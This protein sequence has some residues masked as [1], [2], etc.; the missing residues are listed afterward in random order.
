MTDAPQVRTTPAR[1]PRLPGRDVAFDGA[2]F[3]AGVL[4]ALV[5]LVRWLAGGPALTPALVVAAALVPLISYF[6]FLL[7]QKAGDSNIGLDP[8]VLVF[9]VLTG[10]A[11]QSLALWSLGQLASQLVA[12]RSIRVRLFNFGITVLAGALLVLVLGRGDALVRG[13]AGE[14]V[15]VL[16]GC[17]VYFLVDI[18][19]TAVSLALEMRSRLRDA[20]PWALAPV[21]M[22]VFVGIDTVGYLGMLLYRSQ[23][24]WPLALLLIPI[25]TILFAARS[26][27]RSQL[28]HQQ[29]TS[30]LDATARAPEWAD[31]E[32][33]EDALRTYA[34]QIVR[35]SSAQVRDEPP[36][37]EEIGAVLAVEG[38][39]PRYLV[40]ARLANAEPFSGEDQQ[41][42][43]ALTSVAAT[44]VSR[45]RLADEMAFR[46][47]HDPLTGLVNRATFS[48]RLDHGLLRLRRNPTSLLAVLYCDLDGFK[49][50]NDRL[51]HH[52][53]DQVLIGVAERIRGSL[54]PAD[55]AAR[56][57][58]D[59]FAILLEDLVEP[60]DAEHAAERLLT[61]LRQPLLIDGRPTST[62]AS[63]GLAY[64]DGNT[65][66]VELLRLADAAMYRAKNLGRDRLVTFQHSGGQGSHRLEM[67]DRLRQAV[68][69][70]TIEP[71]FQPIVDLVTGGIQGFEALAR[72][73]DPMLGQIGPDVFI[74]VAEQL[75]LIDELGRQM[76]ARA[77]EV[78]VRLLERTGRP[79]AISVNLAPSQVADSAML[80]MAESL[81]ARHPVVPLTLE[82]TERT[83]LGND[84]QTVAV[85]GRLRVAGVRLAVDDFG[86]GYSSIGYLQ[87]F[88]LDVLKVDKSFV[89]TIGEP[90]PLQLIR[91]MLALATAMRLD[92]I[93]EG[94][95]SWDQAAALRQAGC[96]YAQ[97]FLFAA[98][99]D[100]E[101]ALRLCLGGSMD[102]SPLDSISS[103]TGSM[104]LT[105]S[106]G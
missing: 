21:A 94:V 90:G 80:E 42:L 67:E 76:L 26:I 81:R 5:S 56:L 78:G 8:A 70:G 7:S 38:R 37:A 73:T 100:A 9:L 63:M 50:V 69:D 34:E 16:V 13:A 18:F 105:G 66:A 62:R 28:A 59:E 39:P 2:V 40:A 60:A 99:V 6:P 22:L 92:V 15:V 106:S 89:Q 49:N 91:G 10:S 46:A 23:E 17:T 79:Y 12:R 32:T 75:D 61:A 33:V 35:L 14:L 101:A 29:L 47:R 98:A 96:R 87:R 54:R 51:G 58:G 24:Q 36:A 71:H 64:P 104:G 97:G 103:L 68:S 48:D 25:I 31:D 93:A 82:V 88:P 1:W 43:E 3:T 20:I 85:L 27:S 45:R 4:I 30:L 95:E 57:G 65:S 41:A 53:G 86:V 77:H 84:E 11:T 72:W 83:V 102:L 19:A 52:A 74:P 44:M 55:T